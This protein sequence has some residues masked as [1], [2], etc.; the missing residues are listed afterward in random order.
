MVNVISVEKMSTINMGV[1][2]GGASKYPWDTIS[3]GGGFSL[4]LSS[5]KKTDYRPTVPLRLMKEGVKFISRKTDV[6]GVPSIVLK[7]VA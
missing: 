4:P 7:R 5:L 6:D 3:I 2:K 1:G